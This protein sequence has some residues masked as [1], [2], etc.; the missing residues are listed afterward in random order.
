M[1]LTILKQ[2]YSEWQFSKETNI[3]PFVERLFHG[4]IVDDKGKVLTPSPIRT[5]KNIPCI[6]DF[7][8]STYGR[9]KDKLLYRCI[10]DDKTIPQFVVP[11]EQKQVGFVKHKTNKYVLIQFK[12]WSKGEKHPTGSLTNT[13]GDTNN[14]YALGEYQLYCKNLVISLKHLNK[15]T[16]IVKNIGRQVLVD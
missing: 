4:D 11:Y 9:A 8:G 14:H 10:P 3:N 12:S 2:D 13:I 7:K 1:E 15:H 5:E 16:H 6:L